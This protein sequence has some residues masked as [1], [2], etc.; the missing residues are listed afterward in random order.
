MVVDEE[1]ARDRE[2]FELYIRWWSIALA[3]LLSWSDAQ[4]SEWIEKRRVHFTTS[5]SI[6]ALRTQTPAY[7]IVADLIPEMLRVE[8]GVKTTESYVQFTGRVRRAIE[9]NRSLAFYN[10]AAT[11]WVSCRDRV[12]AVLGE[13]GYSLP[14]VDHGQ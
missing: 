10:D 13:F 14:G 4:V 1:D 9:G 6:M 2:E 11:D 12:N 5:S 8:L 3:E 7:Y